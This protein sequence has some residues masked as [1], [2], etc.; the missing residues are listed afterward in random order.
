MFMSKEDFMKSNKGYGA[1]Y[2]SSDPKLQMEAE[3][4][5]QRY[6][7]QQRS[8]LTRQG[9]NIQANMRNPYFMDAM[10]YDQ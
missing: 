2:S 7:N 6:L 1:A 10:D 4:A 5:Y 8:M 9:A 3:N